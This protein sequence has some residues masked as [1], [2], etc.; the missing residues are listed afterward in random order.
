MFGNTEYVDVTICPG[1]QEPE[2]LEPRVHAGILLD[3]SGS[4]ARYAKQL[5]T[6]WQKMVATLNKR[7][8]E[9]L[10]IELA[11]C[12]FDDRVVYQDY[13]PVPYYLEKPL[14]FEGGG[15]TAL[16]TALL[17]VIQHTQRRREA[18]SSKGVHCYRSMCP[19]VSDGLANDGNVIE[20]AIGEIRKAEQ[21]REIDFVP[22]A[23]DPACIGQL[24]TIFGK[25]SVLLL[26][27]VRFDILFAAL[28]RSL[29]RYSQSTPGFEPDA[30]QLIQIE[31]DR[32]PA[33]PPLPHPQAVRRIKHGGT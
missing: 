14:T 3:F 25:G 16:G 24:E 29:S 26:P 31:L 28:T 2:N 22:L 5:P 8:V 27:E 17:T 32:E 1:A 33:Q 23:P 4:M 18:L 15:M 9:R 7:T 6:V 13:A 10:R 12:A 30:R 19:V 20:T 11:C 21:S